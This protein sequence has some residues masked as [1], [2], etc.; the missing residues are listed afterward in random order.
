MIVPKNIQPERSL[1]AIGAAV[2]RVLEDSK[3]SIVDPEKVYESFVK[4]YPI[5]IS[6]SYFL[7]SLDWLFLIG[8]INLSEDTKKIQKCF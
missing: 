4:N 6:Y 7:Y 8:L 3:T 2:I 5:R 1:Y